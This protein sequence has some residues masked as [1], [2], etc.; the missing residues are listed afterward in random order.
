MRANVPLAALALALALPA[1][2]GLQPRGAGADLVVLCAEARVSRGVVVAPARVEIRGGAVVDVRPLASGATDAPA[3]VPVLDARGGVVTPGLVDLRSG[4][5]IPPSRANEEG[6]EVTP[7]LRAVDLVDPASPDFAR[8]RRAGV[9]TAVVA[10]GGRASIGGLVGAVK[11]DARPLDERT[12]S[13]DLALAITLGNEPWL[14]NRLARFQ[15]PSGLYFRRPATRMGNVAVIRRAFFL[16]ASGE[17]PGD[18]VLRRAAAGELP[19]RLA[20][21]TE[22]D[23]RAALDLARELGLR[24]ILVGAVEAHR[25]VELLAGSRV[26]VVLGP[27]YQQPR[28]LLEAFEGADLRH[29]TP[30]LLADAGVAIALGSGPLEGP[31]LLLDS[32]R[33]AARQGLA[34]DAALAAVT[35]AAAS[36]AGLSARVGSLAAGRDGDLVVFDGDP[37]AATSRVL[38]VVIEGRV[39]HR[40][41][42]VPLL[43]ASPGSP[44]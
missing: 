31:E 19:V 39:V 40:E 1:R 3:G 9:T 6:A 17:T 33:E 44:S 7:S 34:P 42:A 41:P 26:P 25:K 4:C 29:A 12:L 20:A 13:S 27:F 14:G 28:R 37:L 35:D 8:A 15:R 30:R 43:P 10:P 23:L 36:I 21:P 2:A 32:A 22:S 11:T 5:G 38:A 18:A 24:P 16:A